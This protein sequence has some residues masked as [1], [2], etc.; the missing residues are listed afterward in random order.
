MRQRFSAPD[1]KRENEKY[2]ADFAKLKKRSEEA[3]IRLSRSQSETIDLS[4]L[5]VGRGQTGEPFD[6]ELKRAD[7]NRLAEPFVAKSINICRDVL[8]DARLNAGDI[9]KV[10]LVGGPTLMP[11]LRECLL[12]KTRGLGIALE[13]SKDPFTVVA[14]GAAVFAATQPIAQVKPSRAGEFTVNLDYKAIGPDPEPVISGQVMSSDDQDLSGFT[15]EFANRDSEPPWRS[16][17][18]N[19]SADGRFMA[20][21]WAKPGPQNTFLIELLNESGRRQVTKPE[22]FPYTVGTGGIGNQPL[23]H[24]IGVALA[25]NTVAVFFDKGTHLPARIRKVMFTTVTVRSGGTGD[26]L[27]VPVVEGENKRA[28]RN[29]VVGALEIIATNLK[30]DVPEGSEI[31][32]SIEVDESRRFLTKAYLPFL[33]EEY[34]AILVK[35]LVVA[36][37]EELEKLVQIERKRLTDL[38]EKS[39][40]AND[41]KARELLARI[42]NERLEH[43]V[44]TSLAA[45]RNDQDAADRCAGRLRDLQIAL[46]EV[47]EALPWPALVAKAGTTIDIANEVAKKNGTAEDRTTINTLVQEVRE[48]IDHRD[49]ELLRTREDELENRWLAIYERSA[50][51]WVGRL[52][53]LQTKKDRMRNAAEADRLFASGLRA[54]NQNDINGLRASV[55]GLWE[56]LPPREKDQAQ[57]S[58]GSTVRLG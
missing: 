28:D 13:F 20:N 10:I 1:F 8:R 57:N 39:K 37:P 27:R 21:L 14:R 31:E 54:M 18:L 34:E 44:E 43:E 45:A 5:S 38:R 51:C 3:K 42:D 29:E 58:L 4:D 11:Y 2:R 19:L 12:D 32:V 55:K 16:G 56:L 52:G 22:S 26:L 50:E 49:Y 33:D 25:D 53:H 47:E 23:I 15:I 46:D 17:K 48:A 35:H 30:R 9:E 36:K 7:L 24:A 6:F 41:A 40:K